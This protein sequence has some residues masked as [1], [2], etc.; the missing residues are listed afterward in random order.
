VNKKVVKYSLVAVTITCSALFININ[1]SNKW[2][3]STI[4]KVSAKNVSV[5]KESYIPVLVSEGGYFTPVMNSEGNKLL[6]SSGDD[7]YEL[8]LIKNDIRQLTTM[9][10]CYNPVYFEKDNN[11][12]V[13]ARNNGIYKMEIASKNVTKITGSEDQQVSFAKPNF[14]PEGDI[15]YFKV[16][17]LPN[18]DGHGY[19]EKEPSIYKVSKDG[20]SEE[21]IIGG[22]NPVISKDGK[23][24]LYESKENI[25]VMDLET[26]DSKLID[27]GKYASWS[28]NGKYIS[29]AKFQRDAVP[30][31]KL[32][33]KRRLFIDKEFSNIYVADLNNI[34]NKYKLTKEEFENRDGEIESWVNDV[35]DSSAEQHF[36]VVSKIAYFDS[37]WSKDDSELYVSV[38][39]G[40]KGTFELV[41]YKIDN[42]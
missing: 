25:Y 16:T 19:I 27:S 34:K 42:K 4:N 1:Y 39:N 8:D 20:K 36:L 3:N 41:K 33:G 32:K 29:Y 38:Y 21:K 6:Y 17:V 26:K 31:T 14:T 35:K 10:N 22:Y 11:I 30:Y 12:I 7:I 37:V 13:F 9:G 15:I 23:S 2:R 40:D 28:N 18:P 24:L 5:N